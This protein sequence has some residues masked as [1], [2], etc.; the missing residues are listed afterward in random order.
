MIQ[1]ALHLTAAALLAFLAG[2]LPPAVFALALALALAPDLDT[3]RS[4]IGQLCLPLSSALE[5]RIGHRTVTHSLLA[6]ALVAGAASLL[7]PAWWQVLTAAYAS[8]LALDLLIGPQGLMLFW[9]LTQ[10]V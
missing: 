9:P 5:R 6:L 3:P 10:S 1:A 2:D 4:L 8:H 7:L